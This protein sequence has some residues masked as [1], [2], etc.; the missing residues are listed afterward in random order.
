MAP[1]AGEANSSVTVSYTYV[2]VSYFQLHVRYCQLHVTVVV[3][4][5]FF[6]RGKTTSSGRCSLRRGDNE[7][8][9]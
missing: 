6:G 1:F 9:S 5:D 4:D 3:T 7:D 8:P 2:T